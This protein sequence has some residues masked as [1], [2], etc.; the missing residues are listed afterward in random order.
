MNPVAA[1]TISG[2]NLTINDPTLMGVAGVQT[3]TAQGTI[4]CR[5]TDANPVMPF[6]NS[7]II[8]MGRT[9][10]ESQ[11]IAAYSKIR[12]FIYDC[13]FVEHKEAVLEMTE[14]QRYLIKTKNGIPDW[15]FN[16]E[17]TFKEFKM[18]VEMT[19]FFSQRQVEILQNGRAKRHMMGLIPSI[20]TNHAYYNPSTVTDFE[21]MFGNFLYQQAYM[22]KVGTM[23]KMG[24]CGGQFLWNFNKAFRQYRRTE[25]IAPTDVGS[26]A[27]LNLDTYLIPG[28]Y[29]IKIA[30]NDIFRMNTPMENWCVIIDPSL[31]E[32]RIVKNYKSRE[33]A[34]P[35]N[36]DSKV[37]IEWQGSIAWHLEQGHSMLSPY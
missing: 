9:I 4:V 32:W 16:Q 21:D 19:A 24:L 26:V 12:D 2:G 37:M 25:G 31:M 23:K 18:D 22:Y 30:R 13:N 29:E 8:Y 14:D 17:Q 6:T 7:Y 10:Y 36:R 20:K 34:L 33:Y 3:I 35:T 28:G 15:N 27:G 5:T 1:I 11:D